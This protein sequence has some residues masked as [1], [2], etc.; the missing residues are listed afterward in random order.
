MKKYLYKFGLYLVKTFGEVSN[1]EIKEV[2]ET[3]ILGIP[4]YLISASKDLILINS[5]IDASG[6]YKRHVVLSEMMKRFPDKKKSAICLAI[7][8]AYCEM[9]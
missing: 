6:E 1:T 8:L 4:D 7:E 3:S 9:V 2:K 5:K